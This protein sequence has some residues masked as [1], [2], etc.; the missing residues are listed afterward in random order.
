MKITIS[1]ISSE[2]RQRERKS[3]G[4]MKRI[5]E[6]K[7]TYKVTDLCQI[8]FNTSQV[9]NIYE[10]ELGFENNYGERKQKILL[11]NRCLNI[12]KGQL[13]KV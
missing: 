9:S 7:R 11:C 3:G 13:S 5:I 8:C 1:A 6:C 12:L 2:T 4:K 10:L